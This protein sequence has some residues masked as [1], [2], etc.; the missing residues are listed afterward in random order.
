MPRY[1][2]ETRPFIQPLNQLQNIARVTSYVNTELFTTLFASWPPQTLI[3]R[4]SF[5]AR[6]HCRALASSVVSK[7]RCRQHYRGRYGDNKT[8]VLVGEAGLH[9]RMSSQ[10]S[11]KQ[12]YSST[13]VTH[14]STIGRYQFYVA[15]T[16]GP[17]RCS[18][19]YWSC[20][21]TGNFESWPG[22]QKLRVRSVWAYLGLYQR[23]GECC[24]SNAWGRCVCVCV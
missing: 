11:N 2:L 23:S 5:T 15:M 18:S 6:Q 10:N 7:Q 22:A 20:Y 16:W 8:S 17:V 12:G 21:W 1:E 19:P 14:H 9:N 13:Y 3:Q 24:E 4:A